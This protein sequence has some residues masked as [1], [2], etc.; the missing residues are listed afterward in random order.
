MNIGYMRV[1][2]D[3]QDINNQRTAILEYA[4]SKSISGVS[5]Y[6]ETISSTSAN[7]DIYKIIEVLQPGS[8][9]IVYELSRLGRSMRDLESIRVKIAEKG[10]TIHAISQNLIISPD[11]DNITT[12]ALVFALEISAQLERTMISERTKLALQARKSKGMRLGRP[13]GKSKLDERRDEIYHFRSL[14]LNYTAV[15]KIC[16]CNRQT[17]VNWL[18]KQEKKL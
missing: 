10:A 8:N 1:S 13:E 6:E 2:T 7:R 18:N 16:K 14:G 3:K 9:L 4:N 12:R 17:L 15:A 5:F 11:T